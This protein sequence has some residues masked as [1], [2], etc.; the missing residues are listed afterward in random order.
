MTSKA[1]L[2]ARVEAWARN[3][4]ERD[5]ATAHGWPHVERVRRL[6]RALATREGVA[7]WLAECAALLHDVGRAVPGPE[8][9]HGRR[10]AELAAP[11]LAQLPL[12]DAER[13]GILYAIRWHNS[14]RDD[15]PLLCVLRDA[16]MLDGLGAVGLVRALTSKADMPPYDERGA[17]LDGSYVRPPRS[18]ADQIHFQID[19]LGFLNTE[20]ARELARERIAFM[21]AFVERWRTELEDPL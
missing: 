21:Q 14:V 19:W 12:A 20:T 6:A 11:L 10:S 13:D 1:E 16:D 7:P 9:G 4:L 3:L 18:I 2:L 8:S 17:C 15:T 5:G